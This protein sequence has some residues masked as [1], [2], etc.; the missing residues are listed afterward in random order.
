MAKRGFG[1]GRQGGLD[2]QEMLKQ[3]QK[4]QHE[5][6]KAQDELKKKVVKG[7]SGGEAVTAYVN[8]GREV[9]K[10][11]MTKEVVDPEDIEM[12]EDLIMVAMNQAMEKA[13][14]M[15]DKEMSKH[16]GGLSLPGLM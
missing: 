10:I 8:G 11:E 13:N 6:Q 16:T 4:M 12:L 3:A 9:V 2:P 14:K 15:I 7:T 5:M 1:G